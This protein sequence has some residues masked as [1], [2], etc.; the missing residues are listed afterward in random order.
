MNI[1]RTFWKVTRWARA[2]RFWLFLLLALAAWAGFGQG[3]AH[4][5]D[6]V[7]CL[8]DQAGSNSDAW[9]C[10]SRE[11]AYTNALRVANLLNQR[12]DT[13]TPVCSHGV[14]SGTFN[15]YTC[16][17]RTSVQ[18]LNASRTYR[19]NEE[20]PTGS[21]WSDEL[22]KCDQACADK[23]PLGSH[24]SRGNFLVCQGGCQYEQGGGVCLGGG[25]DMYCFAKQWHPTGNQCQASDVPPQPHN[26]DQQ[27]CRS[28]GAGW[29]ECVEPDGRHCVTGAK[30][31]RMCWQPGETGKR[32]DASKL[33]W[34]D[35]VQQGETPTPPDNIENPTTETTTADKGG[36]GG[37]GVGGSF[38][39]GGGSGTG[40]RGGQ[41]DTGQGGSGSGSGNGDGDE[42][43]DDRGAPGSG[44]GDVYDP[45]EKTVESVFAEYRAQAMA[46]DLVS[47][48][49]GI[50]GGCSGGGN[51]PVEVWNA[52]EWGISAD[53]TLLCSGVLASL[54]AFAGWVSLA[55]MGFFAWK[56]A[57]L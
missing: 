23:P 38:V 3:R 56:V 54:I 44:L 51:C 19:K 32:Q 47:F 22:K 55:G 13:H 7:N 48:G 1:E 57:V 12:P 31:T 26:P 30:G 37:D 5:Q 15:W 29:N 2:A 6:T 25:V 27:T 41:S 16:T 40:N 53:L 50:F 49:T 20:C 43:D 34:A 39:I 11:S 21:T 24:S 4:A 9:R 8:S 33:E 18:T 17:F 14:G 45:T 10:A 35:R 28:T 52:A 42:G 46:T 36:I